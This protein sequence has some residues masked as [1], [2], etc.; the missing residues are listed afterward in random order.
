VKAAAN[1]ATESGRVKCS[2]CGLVN[3]ASS[4]SCRRCGRYLPS[5]GGGREPADVVSH[6]GRTLG[7]WLLWTAGVVVTVVV[8]AYASLL[9]TSDGMTREQRESVDDAIAVIEEAGFS[10][11]AFALRHF[12]SYR[13][14]DN[15]WNRYVG[16]HPAFAATN[17]PFGIV[18][19]Y[20]AFFRFPVDDVERAAIL[21]HESHHVRG[22]DEETALRRVWL[23][24]ER[25]GWN[26]VDYGTTRVWKNTREWT[27][28]G[29]PLLFKCGLDGKADCLDRRPAFMQD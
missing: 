24:K 8:L 29:A 9:V 7:Q 1:A 10:K 13:S 23:E 17:F 16:H 25:L 22:A 21:L 15:W 6:G 11:E 18:T 19:V 3:F 26:A 28:A 4:V 5:D 27:V 2:S 12:V 20:P 14:T